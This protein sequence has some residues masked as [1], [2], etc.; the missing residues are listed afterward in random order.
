[1]RSGAY[2]A[3]SEQRSC[4]LA[5]GVS[6]NGFLCT[7]AGGYLI[8]QLPDADS[9][10]MERISKNLATLVERDGGT[11]LP[12]NLLSKGVSPLEIAEILLNGLGLQPLQ[13]I[14]PKF[15][16]QCTSDRLVRALRLLSPADIDEIL[17]KEEKIEARCE[18]CG[19]VYNMTPEEIREEM[20][21][22]KGDP[23][24]DSDFYDSKE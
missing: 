1:M 8:E 5:A 4:A 20:A 22:A 7:S 19:K 14:E 18:F 10:T 24:K 23:A 13:Q 2:L 21:K 17:S 11:T 12:T 9:G 15:Q 6:V 16:C 3:E